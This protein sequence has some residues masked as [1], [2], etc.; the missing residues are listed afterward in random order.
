MSLRQWH[1]LYFIL[2]PPLI[3]I[4]T[5]SLYLP[6]LC[7]PGSGRRKSSL[8]LFQRLITKFEVQSGTDEEHLSFPPG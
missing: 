7:L 2:T 5:G 8:P 1:I 3:L 6:W 4:P